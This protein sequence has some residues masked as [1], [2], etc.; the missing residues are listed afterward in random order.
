MLLIDNFLKFMNKE[1]IGVLIDLLS[2]LKKCLKYISFTSV[3]LL[4][5]FRPLMLF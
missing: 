5:N 3:Q 4:F 2:Y 1:Q